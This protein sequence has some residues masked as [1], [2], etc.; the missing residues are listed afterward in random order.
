M[1]W[2]PFQD[3]EIFMKKLLCALAALSIAIGCLG[4]SGKP[5]VKRYDRV[6]YAMDTVMRLA[7][8][9]SGNGEAVLDGCEN[10]ILRIE[11]LLSL[12]I[13]TSQVSKLN[14]A[15]GEAVEVSAEL[16]GLL[17]D[18]VVASRQT[19]GA[20]DITVEPI[21][22]AWGFFSR[23][24]RVPP[25]DEISSLL[26]LV[27]SNRIEIN[28]NSVRLA[29][30]SAIDLGGIAKG[31]A[32][33][34]LIVLIKASGAEAALL[35]LGGNVQYYGKKPDSSSFVIGIEDPADLSSY[36]L[37]FTADADAAVVTSGDYQ[38]YF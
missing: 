14:A 7:V 35:S 21:V 24:Y 8:F 11:N 30:G 12:T 26:E 28:G 18:A 22:E 32:A 29:E 33:Q 6:V 37:S 31:Y 13:P 23:D 4:C 27:G 1:Q 2:R 34:R 9:T 38:R 5:A 19:G 16:A 36:C 15:S 20:F 10:E 25:D 17:S 3:S